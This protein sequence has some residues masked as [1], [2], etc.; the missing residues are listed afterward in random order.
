MFFVQMRDYLDVAP[1]QQRMAVAPKVR[2]QMI[3]IINLTVTDAHHL[4]A[5]TGKRL[6]SLRG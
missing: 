1:G 5:L 3:V 2:S 4:P 6:T